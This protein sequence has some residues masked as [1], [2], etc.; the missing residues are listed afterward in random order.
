MRVDSHKIFTFGLILSAITALPASAQV[1]VKSDEVLKGND[2]KVL[3][4]PKEILAGLLF[5]QSHT[6]SSVERLQEKLQNLKKQT[7]LDL[8]TVTHERNRLQTL[9][10]S[11][12]QEFATTKNG[13]RY[14]ELKRDIPILESD[15]MDAEREIERLQTEVPAEMARLAYQMRVTPLGKSLAL[16]VIR[17]TECFTAGQHADPDQYVFHELEPLDQQFLA[18]KATACLPAKRVVLQNG[19]FCVTLGNPRRAFEHWNKWYN[20]RTSRSASR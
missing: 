7:A 19:E 20:T 1:C 2:A 17:A 13:T 16:K 8:S 12:R 4:L 15:L 10:R 14:L 18:D 6:S 11:S 9:L 3:A 5:L